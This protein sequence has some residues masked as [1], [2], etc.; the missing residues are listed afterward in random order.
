MTRIKLAAP[1]H[2]V[3]VATDMQ[4]NQAIC[5]PAGALLVR[6]PGERPRVVFRDIPQVEGKLT[7]C[8]GDPGMKKV[9]VK[10][11][12]R[13]E[14]EVTVRP[15]ENKTIDISSAM[16]P[17]SDNVIVVR[18]EGKRGADAEVWVWDG[19]GDLPCE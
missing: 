17:G 13:G 2:V 9:H 10:V 11:N 15:N 19:Q 4:G 6:T 7:I 18:G 3:L 1:I 16:E 14:F 5:D 8:N 12:H